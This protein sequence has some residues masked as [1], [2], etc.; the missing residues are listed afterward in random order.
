MRLPSRILGALLL[1]PAC[2]VAQAE[3]PVEAQTALYALPLVASATALDAEPDAGKGGLGREV[4]ATLERARPAPRRIEP[5]APVEDPTAVVPF[6]EDPARVVPIRPREPTPFARVKRIR[7]RP[8]IVT[9]PR[10]PTPIVREPDHFVSEPSP[11]EC[12]ACGRG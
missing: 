3:T 10:I 9:P 5:L 8:P 4:A 11:W 6:S 2:D 12:P 7:P 1:L